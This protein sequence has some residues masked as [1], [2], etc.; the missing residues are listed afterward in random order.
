MA[1]ASDNDK[2]TQL[3]AVFSNLKDQNERLFQNVCRL[4]SFGHRLMD[5][6]VPPQGS[7]KKEK[8]LERGFIPETFSEIDRFRLLNNRVDEL[9]VKLENII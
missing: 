1:L 2:A 3:V 8:E 6:N 4:E 7:D 5:T 9:L